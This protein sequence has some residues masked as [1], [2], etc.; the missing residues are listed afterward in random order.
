MLVFISVTFFDKS[1]DSRSNSFKTWPIQSL[2][3]SPQVN[4]AIDIACLMKLAVGI[5]Q[6]SP[7]FSFVHVQIEVRVDCACVEQYSNHAAAN[8]VRRHHSV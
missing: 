3:F 6:K 5:T 4:P 1:I 2:N 7:G 8:D